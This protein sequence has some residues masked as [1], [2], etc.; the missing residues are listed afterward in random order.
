M[1]CLKNEQNSDIIYPCFDIAWCHE[2]DGRTLGIEN[3][4]PY[5]KEEIFRRL[6]FPQIQAPFPQTR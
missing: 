3:Y 2:A 1:N 4:K 6:R 5:F